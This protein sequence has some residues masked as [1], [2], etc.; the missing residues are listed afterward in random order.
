M[1]IPVAVVLIVDQDH[2]DRVLNSFNNSKLR[3]LETQVLLNYY[4]GSLQP[5]P[6]PHT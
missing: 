6:P 5:P 3:F 1:P 2:V 4:S